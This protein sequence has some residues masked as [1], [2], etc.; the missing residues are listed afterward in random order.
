[1]LDAWG[2]HGHRLIGAAAADALPPDMP[3]FFRQAGRQLA[4]LNPEPDR[5]R[6]R[7]ERERDPALDGATAP[8]HYVDLELIP[9]ARRAATLALPNR[10][11]YADT[12]RT[13]GV[14]APAAGLLPFRILELTQR[15]RSDFR[16][17]RAA[18]DPETRA[19]IEQR[20]IDDAGILGHYVADASNPAHTTIHHN[21]WTGANPRGYATDRRFHSRFESAFVQAR[22]TAPELR[23]AMQGAP[24]AR[25]QVHA[26]VREG[27][28]AYIARSH[29]LVDRLYA[30][31]KA[32][33][34]D[35]TNTRPEH[36]QFA[37][38]RLAAGAAMLRDLW[39]TA[40]VTSAPADSGTRTPR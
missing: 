25:P 10:F 29:A 23:A 20:I 3:R 37:V 21:G 27:V 33:A 16:R 15:L 28:V 14:D 1:V 22:V 17:W 40:W 5:W 13:L 7:S 8:D 31:D 9:E 39:W 35:S 19:W 26:N 38:D 30:L 32:A 4:Y 34:F 24:H 2:E 12:L 6:D 11:A 36:E 18:T